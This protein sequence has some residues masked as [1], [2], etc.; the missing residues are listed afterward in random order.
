MSERLNVKQLLKRHGLRPKRSWSQNFLV[1]LDVLEQIGRVA[2]IESGDVVVE[3]GAG[4]GA[5]TAVLANSAKRVVAV[6]RDRD[7]AQVLR[8]EFAGDERVLIFEANAASLDWPTLVAGLGQAPIVVGNLPYHMASQ[9]LF[10]LLDEGLGLKSWVIMVQREMAQR[11]VASPG[12]RDFG[13][14]SLQL[15]MRADPEVV[16]TVPPSAFHPAPKV[17]SQVVRGV[18]LGGYRYPVDDHKMFNSLVKS[19]FSQRRKKIRN[20]L[21]STFKGRL[22]MDRIDEILVRLGVFS[23]AR[24][25]QLDLKVFVDL[26]NFFN[27]AITERR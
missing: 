19:V 9:I 8:S 11:M 4:L 22:G 18:P 26:A 24:A 21:K 5:L 16:L 10:H 23:E 15:Q 20:G 7:M 6:E 2:E 13:V 3:L 12:G 25:E 17:L 1:D 14:L 27:A